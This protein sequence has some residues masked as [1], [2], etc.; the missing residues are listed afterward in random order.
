MITAAQ[1]QPALILRADRDVLPEIFELHAE[2][3][4]SL[5]TIRWRRWNGAARHPQIN[6]AITTSD[7]GGGVHENTA[8][9]K[10]IRMMRRI[11]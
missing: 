11:I 1:P 5:A 3:I 4:A 2:A 9:I 10:L 6:S 8:A 7:P